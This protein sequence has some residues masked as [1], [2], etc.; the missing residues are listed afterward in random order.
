M[1]VK[2]P[3][4]IVEKLIKAGKKKDEITIVNSLIL[5][6]LA[7]AFIALGGLVAIRIVAS[8]PKDIWGSMGRLFFAAVFP[9]GLIMIIFTG[10]ELAT[11]NMTTQPL[12][13]L[14]GDIKLKNVFKNWFFVFLGNIIGSLFVAYFFACISGILGA[15]PQASYVVNLANNKIN[16]TWIEAFWRGVGCNWLVGI[17]IWM[18]FATDRLIGKIF[19]VWWPIMTFVAIGFEHS[20]ANTFFVPAG[21]FIGN[22]ASYSGTVLNAGWQTFILKNL[23]P[24]TL[25][26]IFGAVVFVSLTGWYLY[27]YKSH[28]RIVKEGFRESA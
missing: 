5:G 1:K 6:F 14:N 13:W 7:G 2:K 26:N 9:V 24:V 8:L 12:A 11:G 19:A 18:S 28:K 22:T 15:E 21:L 4:M 20:I 17:A 25:G 27:S 23:V 16:M 3:E 10:S